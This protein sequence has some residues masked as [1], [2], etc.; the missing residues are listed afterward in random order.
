MSLTIPER[1][2]P[3]TTLLQQ[4]SRTKYKASPLHFG[5]AAANR[6]DAPDLS[7]G[8]LYLGQD[9]STVLMESVFHKHRWATVKRRTVARAEVYQRMVRFVEVRGDLHL[10]DLAAP[11][12]VAS[13]FGLN[14]AQ[15]AS[16]KYGRLQKM[17]K[18]IHD[19]RDPAG[20]AWFDGIYYPSRNNPAASCIAVFDRASHKVDVVL[21]LDLAQHKD[22]P[23]FV[24]LFQI[25]IV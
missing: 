25:A 1:I 21:D 8:V 13:Q 7:Y 6:Y 3:A 20:Q 4:V 2:V 12:V 9:L 18:A 19:Q 10:A 14:L 15:L 23:G 22:W 16:R 5:Q 17:S 24:T 11:N